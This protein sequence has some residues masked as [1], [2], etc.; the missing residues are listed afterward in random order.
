MVLVAHETAETE[1]ILREHPDPPPG[2]D[3]LIFSV[4]GAMVPYASS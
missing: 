1:R 4:D 3:T 2:P